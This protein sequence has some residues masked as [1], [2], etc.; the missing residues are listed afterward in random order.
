MKEASK[1]KPGTERR[2]LFNRNSLQ[3]KEIVTMIEAASPVCT[4][5]NDTATMDYEVADDGMGW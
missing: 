5:G 2:L 4:A 1:N 3:L